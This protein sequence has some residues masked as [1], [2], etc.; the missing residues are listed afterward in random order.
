MNGSADLLAA[1][2]ALNGVS[3]HVV[4]DAMIDRYVYG[5]VARISPAAPVHVL[6]V[7]RESR[8]LGGAGN[9]VR[10]VAALGAAVSVVAPI[11]DDAEGAALRGRLGERKRDG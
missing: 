11:G 4:G 2:H 8:S 3:V 1:L 5:E 10:N 9:V 6:R 7:Q